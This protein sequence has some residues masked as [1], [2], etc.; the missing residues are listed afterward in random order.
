[1]TTLHVDVRIK[2]YRNNN[3]AEQVMRI[4]KE[5]EKVLYDNQLRT[6]ELWKIEKFTKIAEYG[7]NDFGTHE[8]PIIR[9]HPVCC[10]ESKQN[11]LFIYIHN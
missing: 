10:V 5:M 11:K 1:M 7:Q 3:G 6:L 4:I 9:S 2:M 8:I